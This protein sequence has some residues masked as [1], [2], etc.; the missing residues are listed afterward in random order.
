MAWFYSARWPEI[1]P[2]Y[3]AQQTA[4]WC[5]N[6]S[7]SVRREIPFRIVMV[8]F[9]PRRATDTFARQQISDDLRLPLLEA[10]LS[11]RTA[12]QA[13]TWSGVMPSSGPVWREAEALAD[14]LV[15]LGWIPEESL[16]PSE[17][18]PSY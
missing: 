16:Q 11:D 9:D 18:S 1:G 14:E 8:A 2:P 10:T 17:A 13:L 12:Y 5:A 7:A 3:T 15:R 6:L 4:E